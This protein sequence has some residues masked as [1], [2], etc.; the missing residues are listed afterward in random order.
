MTRRPHV[1]IEALQ[2]RPNPAGT[3]TGIIDLCQ[4][5]AAED[6]GFDFTILTVAPDLFGDIR[7]HPHWQVQGCPQAGPGSFKKALFTQFRLPGLVRDLNGDLLHSMQFLVPLRCSVPQVATV[8]DLAWLLFPDTIEKLRRSYYRWLVPR[9]LDAVDAI[10]ANSASTAAD[11]AQYFPG[12]A[13][14]IHVTPHG[15]PSWVLER[16]ANHVGDPVPAERPFFLFV[17]TLEPRKNLGRLME[18]YDLFLGSAAVQAVGE[19]SVPDLVFVGGKGWR[20]SELLRPMEALSRRG[21]LKVL[22]YCSPDDLWQLYRS[23]LALVFP[24][25]HEGF[26]LPVLEAMACGLPVLTSNQGGTAEVAGEQALLVKPDSVQD[27]ASGLSR[28]TFAKELRD[29]L[30]AGGPARARQ[31]SWS[32][33]AELT[34]EVYK[35]ILDHQKVK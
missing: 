25:L 31:W 5:L 27:I 11:T 35:G 19:D 30:A 32:R 23:A 13:D 34:V 18:A 22:D 14:K 21:K 15:T 7:D 2:V 17:G 3:A 33:T 8:H 6:R 26:G 10:V 4:A 16:L 12:T 9:S 29:R 28:L 20:D 24:S 1:V